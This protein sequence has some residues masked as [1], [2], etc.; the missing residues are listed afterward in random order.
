MASD[1][2]QSGHTTGLLATKVVDVRTT[3]ISRLL[4]RTA[5]AGERP[6]AVKPESSRVPVATFDAS[7]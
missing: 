4:E 2:Q 3:P 1:S 5:A 7:L 6:S